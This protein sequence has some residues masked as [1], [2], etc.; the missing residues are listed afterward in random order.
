[1]KYTRLF[2]AIAV[3]ACLSIPPLAYAAFPSQATFTGTVTK[4]VGNVIWFNTNSAA[5]YSAETSAA[6]MVRKNGA[7]MHFSEIVIGDKV[8]ITGQVWQDNSINAKYVRNMSLYPRAG[9]FSGKI[10]GLDPA[11][12]K[13][14]FLTKDGEK[15]AQTD[16]YTVFK[17]NTNVSMFS[18][19]E[20][21]WSVVV[22]GVW[23]RNNALIVAKNVQA[24]VRLVNIDVSGKIGMI[25]PGG[26]TVIGN[27]NVIY[28]ADITK[29][30]LM[31]RKNKAAA[32]N[33]FVPGD[34]VRVW[35]K[36][37]SGQ[38]KITAQKIKNNSLPRP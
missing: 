8:K 34:D 38:I 9:T 37:I 25:V 21:G 32:I 20:L 27:N 14:T 35:G 18:E 2:A 26:I 24:N 31:D 28:G 30:V 22:K 13:F 16:L 5:T 17:K 19:L 10:T 23:E 3:A 6:Q 11:G 4:L 29:A 12:Q 7:A 15:T 1:M 36:H 33:L